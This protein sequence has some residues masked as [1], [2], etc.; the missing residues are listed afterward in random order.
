V[1]PLITIAALVLLGLL[2]WWVSRALYRRI[3]RRQLLAA[4]LPQEAIAI[5]QRR[6]PLYSR[7]TTQQQRLMQGCINRFLFDMVFVGCNG[8]EVSDEVRLTVAG[9]ACLLIFNRERRYYSGFETILIYPDTILSRQVHYDGLVETHYDSARAG[10][11]WHRGP[12]VLSWS[13]VERGLLHG[14]DGHNVILHEFAHKLDEE[15]TVMD[16]LPVLREPAHYRQWAE[17]LTREYREFLHRVDGG[18][19]KVIDGYGAVS[20]VEF[21]AVATESFFEK[22]K[23][24]K[25]QLPELYGQFRQ[26]YGLDPSAW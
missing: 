24:M 22:P 18:R 1:S 14:R 3:R 7:L 19:N 6:V 21:F 12:I 26:F 13:D 25:S 17:V 11:S 15:N 5:L 4:P 20:A 23:R 16:G 9:N 10:E 2:I 8:F